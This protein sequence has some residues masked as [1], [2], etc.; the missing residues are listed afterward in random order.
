LACIPAPPLRLDITELI[1]MKSPSDQRF[2]WL[3]ANAIAIALALAACS[4]GGGGG[5][6]H[7]P[8]ILIGAAFGGGGPSPVAGDHLLLTFSEQVK[9]ANQP[10]ADAD[11]TWSGGATFGT[12]ATAAV[13]T[14]ARQLL[15]T[16]G[17]GVA[18]TPGT[19]TI[20][21]SAANDVVLDLA[22][23][24]GI[25]ATPVT[26]GTDDGAAP[27]IGFLTL[28][29]IDAILNGTGPAGGTLQVP[30]NGWNIDVAYADAGLGVKPSATQITANVDTHTGGTTHP[31]GTNLVPHLTTVSAL[32]TSARFAV[33]AAMTFPDGP[34]TLSCTVVDFGGRAS[35]A[36]TFAFRVHHW[37]DVLR[38]FETSAHPTQVWF[39]DTSRDIER[40]TT[41]AIAGGAQVNVTS[42]PNG[43]SDFLDVLFLLGLQSS[44]PI[45]NVIG[46]LDSNQV[47]VQQF[48]DAMLT[49]LGNLYPGVNVQF[50]FTQPA[51]SFGSATS[52]AYAS[53]GY[54]QIMLTGSA[55]LA[56]VLGAA[57]LD[58][59]NQ[60]QNNDCLV[61]SASTQRL[62]V[63]LETM[64]EAGFQPPAGSSFRVDFNP[65]APA[66]GG[67]PIGNDAADGQRL[68]NVVNDGRAT[69]IDNAIGD[70]ARF[71]A[72]VTA[73]ECGHSLGL[74][75]DGPMPIGLYG[76][77][78]TNFPGSTSGHIRTQSLFPSGGTNVM[79]PQL[80]YDLTLDLHTKFESLNI[81]YLREQVLYGN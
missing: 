30:E 28:N 16:L 13:Q 35:T 11:F 70:F 10:F 72:V 62:G 56:G 36:A 25:A 50:T 42:T 63:F 61:E 55:D 1:G 31:A 76:G 49:E 57:Q 24:R 18:F 69:Q 71:A 46:S 47:V 8:P 67:T 27:T 40:Y 17:T 78:P 58:P 3:W 29:A 65:F 5:G 33:P 75:A 2:P 77:D 23:N 64:V 52:F 79:S 26:I 54:S 41:T 44:T 12:G 51:G 7:A 80:S 19:T 48:Q 81:A 60:R 32:A 34:V 6:D 68:T 53:F 37:T 20:E 43:R 74:V 14:D 39:L 9:L 21:L 38:P 4:G 45:P 15:V 66:L 59:N 22:G 73:H